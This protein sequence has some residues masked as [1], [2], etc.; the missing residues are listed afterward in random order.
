MQQVEHNDKARMRSPVTS[1]LLVVVVV[2]VLRDRLSKFSKLLWPDSV[3]I[4]NS[5]SL[6]F[7]TFKSVSIISERKLGVK[8]E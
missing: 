6:L 3:S 5:H 1:W 4:P 7:V 8:I 2:V